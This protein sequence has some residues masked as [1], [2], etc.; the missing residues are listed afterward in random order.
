MSSNKLEMAKELA[1]TILN[2][3]K[4]G[5]R[6]TE[7]NKADGNITL[8]STIFRDVYISGFIEYFLIVNLY[9]QYNKDK[10]WTNAEIYTFTLDVY[11][12][13]NF[14]DEEKSFYQKLVTDE[15]TR[16]RWNVDGS[17]I[18][19]K[20]HARLCH[21]CKFPIRAEEEKSPILEKA[22]KIIKIKRRIVDNEEYIAK[23]TEATLEL[24]IYDYLKKKFGNKTIETAKVA[25]KNKVNLNPQSTSDTNSENL[26]NKKIEKAETILD[27]PYKY[28][29]EYDKIEKQFSLEH[30]PKLSAPLIGIFLAVGTTLLI[31]F[32]L[33]LNGI[34]DEVQGIVAGLIIGGIA[35]FAQRQ[36]Q[37]NYSVKYSEKMIKVEKELIS[38]AKH[39]N[40]NQ[41]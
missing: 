25:N 2:I 28:R 34:D 4:N 10:S 1:D 35:Y 17:Y 12:G 13:L 26:K 33:R 40:I 31:N 5:L 30:E 36:N 9:S 20:A 14:T 6:N 39:E 15:E 29:E 3:L 16:K 27:L 21:I 23:L 8:P 37:I 11:K 38:R 41:V 24:T 19:G 7:Y 32:V 22:R 18:I